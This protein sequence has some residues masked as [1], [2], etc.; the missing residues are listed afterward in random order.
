[1]GSSASKVA[2]KAAGAAGR[3]RQYPSTSS[4]LNSASSTAD[5]PPATMN[6]PPPSTSTT[7]ARVPPNQ[8]AA[9][10]AETR[11]KHID[12]DGR[13]PHFGSAL[14]RLGPA[15][16][17]HQT[18]PN[19]DA[20]PTSSQPMQLGKNIFPSG[21]PGSNPALTLVRARDRIGRQWEEENTSWGRSSFSGRTLISAKDIAEALRLRDEVGKRSQEVEKQM[22]LK[23]GVLESLAARGVVTNA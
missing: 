2:G 22:R 5:G 23:P 14:R 8:A 17:A 19:E 10:P 7:S 9:P 6:A 4:L 15:R 20:F 3:R 11:S 12:L 21:A 1:M 13:D 16:S 18:R